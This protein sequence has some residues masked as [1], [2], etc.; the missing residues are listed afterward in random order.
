M[1]A[2]CFSSA[3]ALDDETGGALEI[4]RGIAVRLERRAG[5]VGDFMR[6]GTGAL[7]PQKVDKGRLAGIGVLLGALAQLLGG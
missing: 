3:L 1:A 4:V 2:I 5:L 7:E 6:P